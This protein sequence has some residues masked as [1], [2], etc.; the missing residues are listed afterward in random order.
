MSTPQSLNVTSN[1][2]GARPL[3]SEVRRIDAAACLHFEEAEELNPSC[4]ESGVPKAGEGEDDDVVA[5]KSSRFRAQNPHKCLP[6]NLFHLPPSSQL[7]G[8]FVEE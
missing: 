7:S 5:I 6:L 1:Q 8:V 4:K 2:P 3:D